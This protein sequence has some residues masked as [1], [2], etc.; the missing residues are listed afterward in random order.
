M[1]NPRQ[2]TVSPLTLAIEA[3]LRSIPAGKVSTYGRIAQLSGLPN[4]ARQVVR[5]LHSRA[6]VS[7]LPWHRVLAQGKKQGTARIALGGDGFD[8]Q[9]ILLRS[10][11]VE[12]GEDGTVDFYRFGFP[13]DSA[14]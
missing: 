5:I 7:E 10:E 6:M 12:V 14:N 9:R 1:K 11:G 2:T 4:G 3:A 13:A 8:E